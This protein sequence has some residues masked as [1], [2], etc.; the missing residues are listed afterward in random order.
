VLRRVATD[1]D[2]PDV[3]R[4]LTVSLRRMRTHTRT[5]F[6]ELGVSSRRAAVRQIEELNLLSLTR[7]H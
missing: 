5:I 6:D 7:T 2:G 4:E 3:V 1:V